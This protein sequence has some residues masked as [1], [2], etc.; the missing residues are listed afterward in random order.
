MSRVA[1]AGSGLT[2]CLLAIRLARAGHDVHVYDKRSDM[3]VQDLDGGRSINLALSTR[4]IDALAQ[5]G[6]DG[7]VLEHAVPMTGRMIHAVDGDLTYQPYGTEAHQVLQS[8]NRDDLNIALLNAVE[9]EA[10]TK[11]HFE[12]RVRDLSVRAG[13]ITV[14]GPDGRVVEDYDV[15]YGADGAYSAVR[16]RL[17]RIGR[18]DFSQEF[19]THG[20][21]ELTFPAGPDGD[22]QI[23]TNALHIWPRGTHMMIALPNP[24]GSFTG[25]LFW[26]YADTVGFDSVTSADDVERVFRNQFPDALDLMPDVADQYLA[27]ATASLVTMRSGPWYHEGRVLIIGDAAHAVVPFYGQGANAALED[28][29]ILMDLYEAHGHENHHTVFEAFY[30]ERKPHADA[31][32]QLAVDNFVEMRDSVGSRW[33]L[34]TKRVERALHRIAPERFVPLYTMVSFTRTP[35]ADA[36]ARDDRQQRWLVRLI[37]AVAG[38]LLALVVLIVLI[39]AT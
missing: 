31:L 36:V 6:L 12:H 28:V 7:I 33:F 11:V 20:Y 23:E 19:L 5:V 35:Y 16:G 22:Y 32:A 21:K 27:N 17:Q 3:R 18:V 13:R 1:V 34:F 30:Q 29:T 37:G 14:D 25:T 15:V 26:P 9:A 2:G 10:R 24:D 8:V 39:L 4:G 38:L